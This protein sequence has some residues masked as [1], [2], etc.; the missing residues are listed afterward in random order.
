MAQEH[1]E[2][3]IGRLITDREFAEAFF[4][5]PDEVLQEYDLTEDERVRLKAMKQDES[6]KFAGNLDDRSGTAR[7]AFV[8]AHKYFSSHIENLSQKCKK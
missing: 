5:N 4:A 7:A 3:I 2:T 6:S 8:Y 1:V